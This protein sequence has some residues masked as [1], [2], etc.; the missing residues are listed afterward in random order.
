MFVESGTEVKIDPFTIQSLIAWLEKQPADSPYVYD[1]PQYCLLYQY[2]KAAGVDFKSIG[3]GY[4]RYS[5]EHTEPLPP[6]FEY[7]ALGRDGEKEH[8][9]FGKA[10]ARARSAA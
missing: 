7:T 5:G 1:S 6:A 4:I 2:F 8:C 9:T 10:L 3:P